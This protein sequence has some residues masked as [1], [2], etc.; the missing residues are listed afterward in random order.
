[1]GVKIDMSPVEVWLSRIEAANENIASLTT[2]DNLVVNQLIECEVVAGVTV[3]A[4]ITKK[5]KWTT[6]MAKNVHR[7]VN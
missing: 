6:M 2:I 4:M 3:N 7:V 5:P 1:M